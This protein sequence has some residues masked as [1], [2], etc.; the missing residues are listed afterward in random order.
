MATY[1]DLTTD[2]NKLK[3]E[4]K[5]NADIEYYIDNAESDILAF[6]TKISSPIA[7]TVLAAGGNVALGKENLSYASDAA[8]VMLRYHQDDPATLTSTEEVKYLDALKRAIAKLVEMRIKA[9]NI[10]VGVKSERRGR[11]WIEYNTE[12]ST[13]EDSV[14]AA[15]Q[16][17]LSQ[18]DLRPPI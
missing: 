4:T 15:V 13:V 3:K 17:I 18:Y 14:P 16:L 9:T 10:P 5:D 11:R 12:Q 6:Y 8:R 1:F 7:N 2:G